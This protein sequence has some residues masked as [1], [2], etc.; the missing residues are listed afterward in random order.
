MTATDISATAY[1]TSAMGSDI[2]GSTGIVAHFTGLIRAGELPAGA[3]M[4]SI[5]GLAGDLGVAPGTVRRAYGELESQGLIVTSP[6]RPSRVAER[7]Q[8][9]CEVLA[10]VQVLVSAARRQGLNRSEVQD[11]VG[12]MWDLP[13]PEL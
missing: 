2:D 9:P 1:M 10:A 4:P 12:A 11:V 13:E 7:E 6:G 3:E 5:R 8:A